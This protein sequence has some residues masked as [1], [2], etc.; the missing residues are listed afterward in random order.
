MNKHLIRIGIYLSLAFLT[1]LIY[2]Y[3][4][5]FWNLA[6]SES[7]L[8][9]YLVVPVE[10]FAYSLAPKEDIVGILVIVGLILTIIFIFLATYD[11]L[12]FLKLNL[13]KNFKEK[14]ASKK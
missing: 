12:K 8:N 6:S 10:K 5:I 11:I 4:G 1:S 3:F 13:K 14:L 9:K 2:Y 7:F